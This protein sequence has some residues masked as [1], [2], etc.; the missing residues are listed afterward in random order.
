[1]VT[2]VLECAPELVVLLD[3][4]EVA[5]HRITLKSSDLIS[6]SGSATAIKPVLA[7]VTDERRIDSILSSLQIDTI[8]HA[9]AVKH[10]PLLETEPEAAVVN[11]VLGTRVLAFA[12]GQHKVR[13]FVLVST[14]KA[15]RPSSVM[16]ATKRAAELVVSEASERFSQTIFSSVRFGNVLGSSGSV[17]ERFT[18]QIRAGGPVTVTHPEMMRYFMTVEEAASLVME[19]AALAKG[20]ETF[21]LD[22]GAPHGI[23]DLAKTMIGL[24]GYTVRSA[25]T[26]DGDI[27]I[28]FTGIRPGEKLNEELMLDA[29]SAIGTEHPKIAKLPREQVSQARIQIA[30]NRLKQAVDEADERKIV[31]ELNALVAHQSPDLTAA[32]VEAAPPVTYLH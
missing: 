6:S 13:R 27:E 5:L 14:D 10:V 22:M 1:L 21:I 15:V 17:V 20:G 29:G 9:A 30:I 23:L 32:S 25:E 28:K 2:Q 3:N 11:N 24:M 12:A 8:F 16:G 31:A 18:D 4:S 19:A 26:P 7:S